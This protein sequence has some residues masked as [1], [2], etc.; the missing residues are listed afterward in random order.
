M[1]KLHRVV[2]LWAAAN[3]ATSCA[4]NDKEVGSSGSSLE[5]VRPRQDAGVDAGRPPRDFYVA[6]TGLDTNPGSA[7]LPFATFQRAMSGTIPGDRVLVRAGV[8]LGGG[9]INARGTDVA[10]IQ[11]LSV[12]GPQR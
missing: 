6:T 9:W 1:G 2:C 12:D 8:Y 7:D 3:L 11:L 4:P 10:P 5:A